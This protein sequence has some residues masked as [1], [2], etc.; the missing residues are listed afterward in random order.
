[1]NVETYKNALDR[2]GL[3]IIKVLNCQGIYIYISYEA[4]LQYRRVHAF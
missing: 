1:M 3:C 4:S 2:D